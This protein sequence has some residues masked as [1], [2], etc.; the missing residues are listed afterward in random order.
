MQRHL[1]LWL[2]YCISGLIV[3]GAGLSVFGE[4]LAL[5]MSNAETSTWFWWGTAA[6]IIFNSGIA[7]FG[8]GVKHR[9]HYERN[10]KSE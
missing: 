10:R 6:L 1:N 4:A 3:I 7:L 2:I 8:N 5:K 9:V